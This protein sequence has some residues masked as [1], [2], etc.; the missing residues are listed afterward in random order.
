MTFTVMKTV[1][2]TN[3]LNGL[4]SVMVHPSVKM[5]LMNTLIFART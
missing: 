5:E 4:I 3:V 2:I 1:R